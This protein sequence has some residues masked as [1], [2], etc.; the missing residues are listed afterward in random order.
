MASTVTPSRRTTSPAI[1]S[2]NIKVMLTRSYAPNYGTNQFVS[3]ILLA[4]RVASSGNLAGKTFTGGA[5]FSTAFTFTAV[6]AGAACDFLIIYLDT[7]V[8]GTSILLCGL[9]TGFTGLPVTP[10]GSDIV[11]TPVA[12]GLFVL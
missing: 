2:D 3:D 12:G 8:V 1:T 5:F 10:D 9:D 11:V 4:S 7:G 6:P